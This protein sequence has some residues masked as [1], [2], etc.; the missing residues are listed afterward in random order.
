MIRTVTKSKFM[1]RWT[2][3]ARTAAAD[4]PTSGSVPPLWKKPSPIH[5][6][7]QITTECGPQFK[8]ASGFAVGAQHAAPLLLCAVLRGRARPSNCTK[9]AK[10]CH[11]GQAE[12]LYFQSDAK[13]DFSPIARMTIMRQ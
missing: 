6:R 1:P 13:K 2:R 7:T 9:S 5:Y 12:I 10:F 4:R 3:S 8:Q 11:L